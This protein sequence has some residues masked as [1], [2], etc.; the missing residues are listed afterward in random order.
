MVTLVPH[1]Y[2]PSASGWFQQWVLFS[3]LAARSY[4]KLGLLRRSRPV[5]P[6]IPGGVLSLFD[7]LMEVS[8]TIPAVRLG[9]RY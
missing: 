8:Q 1:T 2:A 4:E 5:D 7:Q 9:L 6:A 3:G